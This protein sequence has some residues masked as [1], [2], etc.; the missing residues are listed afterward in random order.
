MSRARLFY[1]AEC[2]GDVVDTTGPGRVAEYRRGIELPIPDDFTIPTCRSCG[3]TYLSVE[4]S[5]R[6]EKRQRPAFEAWLRAHGAELIELLLARHRTSLRHLETACG[7]TSTYLSHVKSGRK[8]ASL[9]LLRLLEAFVATPAE[10]DRHLEGRPWRRPEL[11]L[12]ALRVGTGP[13]PPG[14]ISAQPFVVTATEP[15]GYRAA[16]IGLAAPSNDNIAA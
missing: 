11:S 13:T 7:L 2:G 6:L 5:D 1:C 8:T 3:E 4:R 14:Q 16:P 15:A 10:L 9:P 12:D